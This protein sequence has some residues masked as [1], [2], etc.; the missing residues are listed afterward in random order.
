MMQRVSTSKYSIPRILVKCIASL[1]VL[2]VPRSSEPGSS[3]E[4]SFVVVA[5]KL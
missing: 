1:I 4:V 2:G 5:V 3:R